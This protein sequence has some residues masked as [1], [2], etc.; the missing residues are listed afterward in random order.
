MSTDL[1][2]I[3]LNYEMITDALDTLE[4]PCWLFE[5]ILPCSILFIRL[6]FVRLLDLLSIVFLRRLLFVL[7]LNYGKF[8]HD[9]RRLIF[10][11]LVNGCT[12]ILSTLS[13]ILTLTLMVIFLLYQAYTFHFL[14][15]SFGRKS[16]ILTLCFDLLSCDRSVI[17]SLCCL[18]V[19]ICIVHRFYLV[20]F[21]LV[22]SSDHIK[23]LLDPIW[24]LQLSLRINN[25]CTLIFLRF[26]WILRIITKKYMWFWF[27]FD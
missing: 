27:S 6:S 7:G 9:C 22:A 2:P 20:C 26:P 17:S 10:I 13:D 25:S 5:F 18:Y 12:L 11:E 15:L 21:N 1:L 4:L 3:C 19:W 16:A 23:F 8:V 24:N 14:T